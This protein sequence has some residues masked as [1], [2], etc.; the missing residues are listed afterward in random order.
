MPASVVIISISGPRASGTSGF[1]A[2]VKKLP[3]KK[4]DVTPEFLLQDGHVEADHKLGSLITI[5]DAM[6]QLGP[7]LTILKMIKVYKKLINIEENA[8]G[9]VVIFT[10]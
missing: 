1:L 8:Q 2:A 10:E 9:N 4:L 5:E 7:L 3:W 6:P